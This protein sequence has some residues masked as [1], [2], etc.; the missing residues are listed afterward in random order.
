MN[1]QPP[2]LQLPRG[3]NFD[4]IVYAVI[5]DIADAIDGWSAGASR[6]EPSL[7]N[8][9]SEKLKRKRNKCDIGTSHPMEMTVDYFELHRKGTRQTDQYGSDLAITFEIVNAGIKKTVFFQMKVSNKHQMTLVSDQL[10]QPS[11]F[12]GVAERS[13]VFAVDEVWKSCRVRHTSACA[14][15]IPENH[16]TKQFDVSQWDLLAEWIPAWF[17]CDKAPPTKETDPIKVEG[18]LDAYKLPDNVNIYQQTIRANLPPNILPARAW[19]TYSFKKAGLED[20]PRKL[21]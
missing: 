13:F 15:E 16:A 5:E 14:G 12:P 3:V 21:L 1:T 6:E 9:I 17:R 20:T 10:L 4:K 2:T 18:L 11:A 8:R 19:L 7:L